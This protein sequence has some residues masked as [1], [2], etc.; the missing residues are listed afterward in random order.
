MTTTYKL[1]CI[2]FWLAVLMGV[3]GCVMTFIPGA[4][5]GWFTVVAALSLSGLFIPKFFYRG[6]ATLLLILSILA[7][8][9]GHQRGIEYRRWLAT[10]Q[11]TK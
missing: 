7:A 6:A 4:E 10:H 8:I 11:T 2:P 3:L 5:C 1:L 9:H